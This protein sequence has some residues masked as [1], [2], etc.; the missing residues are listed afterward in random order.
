M[1][2]EQED[3]F[4]YITLMNENYHHPAMPEGA[5]EGSLRGMYLL[6]EGSGSEDRPRV[7]LLGSGTILREVM[8]AADLLAEFG[9]E[10]DVWSVTSF[11]ELRREG[12]EAER[13]NMLH[14]LSEP[15]VP[16]VRSSLS[17]RSGPVVASTDYI[18]AFGEDVPI[19]EVHVNVGDTVTVDDPL[20]TLESDKATMDVPAPFAGV[21]RELHVGVGDRVSQGTPLLS[22]ESTDQDSD[23]PSKASAAASEGA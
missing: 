18:R 9:V 8:A 2:A 17:A 5:E 10:A 3:V 23:T 16:Y 7:Q 13:W 19:I 1:F 14:P 22:M 12:L 6:H 11:T 4:Y 15:R 21:I 20:L